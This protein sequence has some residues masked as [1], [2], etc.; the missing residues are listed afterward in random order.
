MTQNLINPLFKKKEKNKIEASASPISNKEMSEVFIITSDNKKIP[1]EV[2][3][4]N[5]VCLPI[6]KKVQ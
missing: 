2:D 3:F 6:K 5:R 4:E 1:V